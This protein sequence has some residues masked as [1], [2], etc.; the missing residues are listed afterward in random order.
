MFDSL[1]CGGIDITGIFFL[2]ALK[3]IV[4]PWIGLFVSFDN[5][6]SQVDNRAADVSAGIVKPTCSPFVPD[7]SNEGYFGRC[8]YLT[9]SQ[10]DD[11]NV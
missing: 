11:L 1:L 8:H 5:A 6:P 4:S 9:S 2:T 7:M 3:T 10:Y